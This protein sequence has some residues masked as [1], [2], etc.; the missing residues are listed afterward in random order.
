MELNNG[1]PQTIK[2]IAL[3]TSFKVVFYFIKIKNMVLSLK[4]YN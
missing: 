3:L 1:H 4:I 2:K